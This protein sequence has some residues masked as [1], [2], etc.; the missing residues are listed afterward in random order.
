MSA[1][2]SPKVASKTPAA[3]PAASAEWTPPPGRLGNLTTV[4]ETALAKFREELRAEGAF[5]KERHDD[6]TLLRFL[7]ARKFDVPK[8]KEMFLACEKWRK[9]F[10]VDELVKSFKFTEL[11]EVDKYYPQFYH[12]MDKLGRPIYIERLNNLDVK[13]LYVCTTQE[14]LLQQL[15]V[16]YESFLTTRLPACAAAIGHPVE[17][18]LTILDLGGV[19]L[20]NFIRVRDYIAAATTIGQ[21]YYPECMGAFYII[22][23]PW[24]FTAVWAAIKPW[25]DEV[26][27]KKVHILGGPS[28]YKPELLKQIDKE[29]LPKEFGGG[30][31][32]VGGCSMSDVGP[33][34]PAGGK[35]SAISE[36]EK[37]VLEQPAQGQVLSA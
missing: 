36:K 14:R 26:T 4:Q 33:W 7:R 30:C 35:A 17:T 25:L 27:V 34:N 5:V 29:V 22:N 31:E 20:S 32:C 11:A 19:S 18:S 16:E 10:G 2:A 23:A 1:T 3:P 28:A 9:E 37:T 21:N 15:V 6:A 8:S 24:A 12:N 13:A